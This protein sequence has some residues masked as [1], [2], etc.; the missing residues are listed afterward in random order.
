[1]R[2]PMGSLGIGKEG[3]RRE[4][5]MEKMK[6]EGKYSTEFVGQKKVKEDA[7]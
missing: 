5:E 7:I 2:E 1:M 6:E 4:Q 3:W